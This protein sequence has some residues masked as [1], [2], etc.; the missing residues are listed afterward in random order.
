MENVQE[1]RR[2]Y[3]VTLAAV[4]AAIPSASDPNNYLELK[5]IEEQLV[6]ALGDL[7]ELEGLEVEGQGEGES[8][9]GGETSL[10]GDG[11]TLPYP[12]QRPCK[13][14]RR[15]NS[16]QDGNLYA[17][18][19]HD[20]RDLA[21]R[22][23]SLSQYLAD[24]S[25]AAAALD[26]TN[27]QA[28]K[29]LTRIILLEDFGIKWCIPDGHLVPPVPNRLNYILW[30]RDLMAL[31]SPP[32]STMA[33][34][35]TGLDVGCGASLIYPL[36][37]SKLFGWEF[38]GVDVTPEALSA[39]RQNIESNPDLAQLIELQLVEMTVTQQ[40]HFK[41]TD[42][43]NAHRGILTQCAEFFK[44]RTFTFSMCN[45]PFFETIEEAGRNPLT[46]FGGTEV[47]MVYPGG[48]LGFVSQMVEDSLSLKDK[49]YWF[50]TMVGKK[51]TLKQLRKLLH[52]MSDVSALRTTEFVQGRTSRWGIAW[53]FMADPVEAARPLP[54]LLR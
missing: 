31:S 53:S 54:R 45:P 9:G 40:D 5:E 27:P 12:T 50:T 28:C 51:K 7:D 15:T 18:A 41:V 38:L 44:G 42:R 35:I 6:Q 17:M 29:E 37:G 34:T 52:G 11:A 36:L 48:E 13:R 33:A 10:G 32:Q 43:A 46:S 30:L 4:R 8:G 3:E 26:F 21:S 47:E 25:S 22:H 49:I 2:Q 39:A 14:A 20:F 24:T 19:R 1:C 16:N 23:P